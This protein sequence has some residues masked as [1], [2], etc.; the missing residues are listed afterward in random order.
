MIHAGKNNFCENNLLIDCVYPIRYF[1]SVSERY[2]NWQMRGFMS[3]NQFCRNIVYS[4]RGNQ[5]V[6]HL[7]YQF[8]ENVIGLSD[9]NLYWHGPGGEYLVEDPGHARRIPLADW[10][11]LGYDQNSLVADPLF[12]GPE[13]EDF[14]L[15][16]GSPA[17]RLGFQ[18]IDLSR[19]GIRRPG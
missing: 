3:G 6:I 5:N 14:R 19:I 13:H 12:A 4:S 1:D 11:K 9:E 15:L 10:Q 16:P 17:L 7:G 2:A 18:P 8:T